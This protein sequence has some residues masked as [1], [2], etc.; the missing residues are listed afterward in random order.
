MVE[1]IAGIKLKRGKA[2]RMPSSDTSRISTG[3]ICRIIEC[4][5]SL[6]KR[7]S[8]KKNYLGIWHHFNR[9]INRLDI[10]PNKWEQRMVLFVAHLVDQG[11]QSATVKSYISA[12]KCMLRD[13]DYDWDDNHVLLNTFTRVCHM[14]NY[15]VHLRRPI[16]Q[17]LLE[18]ILYEL[19]CIFQQQPYL[20]ILYRAFFALLYYGLFRVVE[21]ARGDHP[22]KACDVHV[23]KLKAKMLFILRKSKT[24]NV[25]DKPQKIKIESTNQSLAGHFCPF[26]LTEDFILMRGSY[27]DVNEQFF[28]FKD[29]FPVL[30]QVRTVLE[31][32][33]KNLNLDPKYFGTHGLCAGR[34]CN[35]LKAG[36][37]IEQIK[38]IGCWKSNAVYH[39]L[40][41]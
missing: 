29:K 21:L 12:I 15:T 26:K 36:Y 14:T 4:L 10:L 19:A 9:F 34:A 31:T 27:L 41:D 37:T 39:Y 5:K 1:I 28:I 40:K 24:H 11:L 16:K 33:I 32:A 2:T 6:K 7:E 3:Q 35:L 18:L 23:S 17:P 8:T 22:V 20:L 25:G 38:L 13:D 30:S